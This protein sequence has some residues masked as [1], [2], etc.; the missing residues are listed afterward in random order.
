M[1]VV[2]VISA[3]VIGHPYQTMASHWALISLMGNTAGNTQLFNNFNK[4]ILPIS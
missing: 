2:V 1:F 3:G 4:I